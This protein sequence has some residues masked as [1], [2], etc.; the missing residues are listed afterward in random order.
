MAR[1]SKNE[2]PQEFADMCRTLAQRITCQ[3]DDPVVQ[4]VHRENAKRMLLASFVAG[5]NCVSSRQVR[6]ASP[7][8]V[9]KALKI[10]V[11]VQGAER[12]EKFNNSFYA[13]HDS[14][15]CS[16]SDKWR[17]TGA[18]RTA[19]QA[20]G[21]RTEVPRSANRTKAS[22][23]RKAR[24]EAALSFYECEGIGHFTREC[25]TRSKRGQSSS[26]QP[27]RNNK[28]ERSRRFGSPGETP[29][30]QTKQDSRKESDSSGNGRWA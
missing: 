18:T 16:D 11:S 12:Q 3:A 27:R 14:R 28:T 26:Q 15:T 21:R 25:P 10:A 29:L 8:S 7:V 2:N 5:L 9:D 6:F 22:S 13:R 4:A 30:S 20:E 24:T 1:Q 17:H 19:S 23:T